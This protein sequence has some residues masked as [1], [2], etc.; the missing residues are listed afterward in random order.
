[1]PQLFP[2]A[3]GSL[4]RAFAKQN[5]NSLRTGL[6]QICSGGAIAGLR[7]FARTHYGMTHK[8]MLFVAYNQAVPI[9]FSGTL[10]DLISKQRHSGICDAWRLPV[11]N[12]AYAHT[13]GLAV[14]ERP[15]NLL[16]AHPTKGATKGAEAHSCAVLNGGAGCALMD[17]GVAQKNVLQSTVEEA[18]ELF[19]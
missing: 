7:L 3:W 2:S 12:I 15:K 10:T 5:H 11:G 4:I 9:H 1:M 8:R 19:R 16:L 13:G 17:S 14:L 18:R 6:V